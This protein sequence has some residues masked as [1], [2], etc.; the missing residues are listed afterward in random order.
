MKLALLGYGNMGQEVERTV[1]ED[2]K[3]EIVSV[4]YRKQED[5]LDIEGIKKANVAIDFTAPQVVLSNIEQVAKLG[6]NMVVGTTGW[7]E[8]LPKVKKIVSKYNIGLIYGQNFSIGANIFFQ[9]VGFASS[10]FNKYGDYDV[11]GFEI[12]HRGK[13]DSPSG[14]AKKLSD[15][16]MKNF[17]KKK[18]LLNTPLDRQIAEEELHFASI[19]GGRN[20]GFH[21]IVFDSP[22]DQIK[23]SHQA[24]NRRG[25][26]LGA[27][28][29]AQF[30]KEK[31]GLYSFDDVFTKVDP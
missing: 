7:Y 24:L 14:T 2:G 10:L 22:A 21:E 20:P 4:S 15:I 9:I 23:L 25:F 26:A 29:A 18:R 28:M 30:I 1:R 17:P 8:Q 5:G 11:Y 12:H 27:L 19:R 16:I 3:H 13:K 31:K 6:V